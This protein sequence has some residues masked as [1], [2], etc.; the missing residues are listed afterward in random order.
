MYKSL[1]PLFYLIKQCSVEAF[2]KGNRGEINVVE[3]GKREVREGI[4][5]GGGRR[6]C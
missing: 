3:L 1:S 5:R 6:C 2:F 4:G